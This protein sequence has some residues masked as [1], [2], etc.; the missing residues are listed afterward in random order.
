MNSNLQQSRDILKMLMSAYH[1]PVAVLDINGNFWMH[2]INMHKALESNGSLKLDNNKI[3]ILDKENKID[4]LKTIE[5]KF[6]INNIQSN[7]SEEEIGCIKIEEGKYLNINVV[8]V[9]K[10]SDTEFKVILVSL[11]NDESQSIQPDHIP[12][13]ISA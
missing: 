10:S 4:T 7:Q 2:N 5:L 3:C 12:Y 1:I 13:Q 6:F 8:K 9:N 11:F